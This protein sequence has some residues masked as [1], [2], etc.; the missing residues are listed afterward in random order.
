MGQPTEPPTATPPADPGATPPANQPPADPAKPATG[1]P[2]ADAMNSDAGRRALAELRAENKK[3]ADQLAGLAPLGELAKA[4]GVKPAAGK[5]DVDTLR[6]EVAAMRQQTADA[7]MH[8]ARLEVAVAKGLTP[9]QGARLVGATREALEA[10]ADA[11]KALFPTAPAAN[12]QPGTPAPDPS[13]GSRGGG[14]IDQLKAAIETARKEGRTADKMRLL[15]E[16]QHRMNPTA[17]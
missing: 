6:E 14:D 2:A 15:V 11:L 7:Q 4:L 16:L 17:R 5:T 3:L 12:G 9:A 13:Q 1:D 10:D 8:A